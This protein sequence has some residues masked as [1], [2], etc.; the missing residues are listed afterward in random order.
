MSAA[1]VNS[2]LDDHIFWNSMRTILLC[3]YFTM[4]FWWLPTVEGGGA[5]MNEEFMGIEEQ[6]KT[7][8]AFEFTIPI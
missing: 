3:E 6:R 8:Y 4:H 7:L 1:E 5:G 2:I